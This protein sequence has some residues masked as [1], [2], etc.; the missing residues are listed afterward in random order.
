MCREV[1]A[2]AERR[3]HDPVSV[4]A[5]T[6]VEAWVPERAEEKKDPHHGEAA[7][8]GRTGVF[9]MWVCKIAYVP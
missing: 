4:Q 5:R 1:P 6:S 8:S 7:S 2:E 3:E 9:C